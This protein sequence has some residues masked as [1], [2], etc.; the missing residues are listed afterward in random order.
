MPSEHGLKL[1]AYGLALAVSLL[2]K[3]G[4]AA[5]AN[6]GERLAR[7]WCVA[8]HMVASNQR[9]PTTDAAPP[10]ATIASRPG[11]D[12]ARIAQFL[13]DPHP[14]MPDMSLTRSEAADLAAY[15]KTLAR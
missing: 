4:L 13:L 5:D 12:A 1:A 2:G 11:F 8:C 10:F 15:I 6:N 7:R 14:K 9:R 3:P